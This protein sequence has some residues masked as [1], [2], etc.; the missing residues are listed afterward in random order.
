MGCKHVWVRCGHANLDKCVKCGKVR[1]RSYEKSL[2]FAKK[3][4]EKLEEKVA[5]C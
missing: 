1:Y 4:V 5:K 3:L 2:T